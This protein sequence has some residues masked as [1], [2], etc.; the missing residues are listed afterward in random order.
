MVQREYLSHFG[1][2]LGFLPRLFT[3]TNS[4]SIW[5]HAVSVGEVAS[6]MPL[7]EALHR[8][9]PHVPIYLSTATVAGRRAA[10]REV[11]SP[12][13]GLF[14]SP[15]DYVSCVRR[16]LRA[17][18]PALLI[19]VET[20]LWPNLYA[21]TKRSGAALAIVNGRISDRSW[22][23]YRRWRHLFVPVLGLPDIVF[24]QSETDYGRYTQL[25]AASKL[26]LEANLKYDASIAR[27]PI[28]IET[29]GA[30]QIWIAASTAGPNERGSLEPSS[31][32]EDDIVIKAF[33]ALALEYP[34]LLLILAPRQPSRFNIVAAKL[35]A[36]GVHFVR[37]TKPK[38]EHTLELPG[39]L[40]LD[41][42]GELA[43]AYSL[44]DVVFV[45]GSIAP[46]GGHNIIEPASA[47]VP[48]I[49]GPHM[50]NFGT[51]TRDFLESDAIVQIER[52]EEL[53]GAV[54][55]FLSNSGAAK[56]LGL[57]ARQ[58]VEGKRGVSE[59][60]AKCIAPL[61]HAAY[62]KPIRGLLTR[63]ILCSF[64]FA[65]RQGGVFK[66]YS[67]EH[68]ADSRPPL[69]VP[70]VS[71]GGITIGGSGKT[72]FAA[73]LV[74]RLRERGFA[75]AIL[76]RGYAR[77]S[78]AKS[79]VFAPGSKVPT[80][81]T[82]DEP[83][84]FLSAGI[85]AVGI[86]ANRYETAELLLRHFPGTD[87]LVLDDGFQHAR[88][89]RDLDVVVIDGLDPFGRDN[90]VPLGR[91][92]EPLSALSRA[93]M[94]VITRADEDFRYRAI[95]D[96]LREYNR[97]APVFRARLLARRWRDYRTGS[98]VTGLTGRPV[99][100]FCGLGNPENFWRK[101]ESLGL[102]VVFRWTFDDHHSYK[103]FE[104]QRIA[105][106]GQAA[107]AE[108][109]VTTQKDR[110]NCPPHLEATIAPFTLAWLEI[111]LE[112]EDE[113]AFFAQLEQALSRRAVA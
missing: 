22:P 32:D 108:I 76:T 62:L 103:P 13:T 106:Q 90:V 44:A 105:H 8:Q 38:W 11:G 24:V 48:V 87:I 7:I 89:K 96:R 53:L 98:Y 1:E 65:W 58:V 33:Q 16:V 56:T 112:L 50:E 2:R 81:L 109:L 51:I 46:R 49:V 78:P 28:H 19:I 54:R 85:G 99:A 70:V 72:P 74:G 111:E 40:L 59:R 45:G 79:L 25:G 29:F 80:A 60:L 68:H 42:I 20:E 73:Y 41:S 88:L 23:R 31:V 55:H 39:V 86:G 6:A 15:L 71:V 94:F 61:Y 77:R 35:Q 67:S 93:N 83:Q 84:I 10:E 17:I 107:G 47:S 43:R 113:E 5:L 14:Y 66:R 92:R 27:A 30:E 95:C 97:T 91:L 37:R 34:R 18:R 100:A 36:A 104:L 101:L 3:R 64:A 9:H 4:G 102:E 110:I 75:P 52:E 69:S 57:R 21:E 12:I 82:G 63:A 26:H